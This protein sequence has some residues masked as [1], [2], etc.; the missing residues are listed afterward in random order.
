MPA[1]AADECR[2]NASYCA[3]VA[4][5]AHTPA[6][7]SDFFEFAEVWQN[8]ADDIDHSDRLITF[9]DALSA[10][11]LIGEEVK[12]I[13]LGAGAFRR[14][15]ASIVAVANA[16]IADQLARFRNRRAD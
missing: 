7:R 6:E 14:L 2:A 8:L 4:Q 16:V 15:T 11:E 13:K 3:E 1:Q 12:E 9:I 5:R 10:G